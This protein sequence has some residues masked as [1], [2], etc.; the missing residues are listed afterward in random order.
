MLWY[1]PFFLLGFLSL[2]CIWAAAGALASRIEDVQATS[3]PL[4]FVLVSV[5]VVGINMAEREFQ[6]IVGL[7]KL[8]NP[9]VVQMF[10]FALDNLGATIGR[11]FVPVVQAATGVVREWTAALAPVIQRLTPIMQEFSNIL[12]NIVALPLIVLG[13]FGDPYSYSP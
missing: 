6:K 4:T 9:G 11:A 3:M 2:A 5:F 1:L 12:G 8:F 7:V 13:S 10:Q